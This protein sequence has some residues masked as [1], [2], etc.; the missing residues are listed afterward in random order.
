VAVAADTCREEESHLD[1]LIALPSSVH[2]LV[3]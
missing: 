1:I 3:I 2:E